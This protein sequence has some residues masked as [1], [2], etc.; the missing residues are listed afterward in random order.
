[1]KPALCKFFMNIMKI[2]VDLDGLYADLNAGFADFY[3]KKKGT[4]IDFEETGRVYGYDNFLGISKEEA[5]DLV[6]EYTQSSAYEQMKPVK[7]S[8]EGIK[9]I[10]KDNDLWIVTSRPEMQKKV[11]REF[12]DKHTPNCFEDIIHTG[13][14]SRDGSHKTTKGEVCEKLGLELFIED[15]IDYVN[16]VLRFD[17]PVIWFRRFGIKDGHDNPLVKPVNTWKEIVEIVTNF[18]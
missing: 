6:D 11:T 18:K 4:N 7:G 10:T 8:V 17:I 5:F 15:Y 14:F 13:Q 16:D 1:M 9:E 12:I 2:G 3:N